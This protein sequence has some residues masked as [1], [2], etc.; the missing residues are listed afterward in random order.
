MNYSRIHDSQMDVLWNLQKQYKAEI[1]E[2]E[3]EEAGKV[4]LAEAIKNG[5]IRFYGARKEK[6]WACCCSITVGFST[7]DYR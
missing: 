7:Y 2:E 6:D 4:R 1:G 3:P 5:G